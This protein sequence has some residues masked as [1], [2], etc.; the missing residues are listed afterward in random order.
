M[1]HLTLRQAADQLGISPDTLRQ[2]IARGA[3][4]G[5][6]IGTIW[7]VTQREVDRYRLGSLG[8]SGRR[9]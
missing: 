2:G 8:R 6:K 3:I 5:R 1:T 9:T 7:T 4:R